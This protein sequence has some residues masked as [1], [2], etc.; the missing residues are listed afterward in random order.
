MKPG[1]LTSEELNFLVAIS[2]HSHVKG[3]S[4]LSILELLS[5]VYIGRPSIAM[6][7]QPTIIE[8]IK[9]FSEHSKLLQFVENILTTK[10]LSL[11]ITLKKDEQTLSQ[12]NQR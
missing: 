10:A 9:R 11:I 1:H 12:V 7:I 2:G 6:T 8:L 3:S 5:T 4:G